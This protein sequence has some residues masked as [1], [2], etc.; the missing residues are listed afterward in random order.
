MEIK[1]IDDE[2]SVTSQ[3]VSSD[4]STIAAAGFETII[5]N[6]PDGEGEDQQAFAE[7]EAAAEAVGISIIYQP[8]QSGNVTD[9]DSVQFG[10]L[11]NNAAKPVLAYCR[12]GTRCTILWSLSRSGKLPV[13]EI[14]GKAA[15]AGYDMS[16]IAARL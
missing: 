9:E 10:K 12:T 11:L 4:L 2:I 3:I 15:K 5:C 16:G 14:L 13:N 6:R 8:V 7:I 1:K